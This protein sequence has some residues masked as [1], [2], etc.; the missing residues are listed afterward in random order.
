MEA[1][2]L[3]GLN[4]GQMPLLTSQKAKASIAGRKK[5]LGKKGLGLCQI[6]RPKSAIQSEIWIISKASL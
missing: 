5:G 1:A 2:S 3:A 4:C 6:G